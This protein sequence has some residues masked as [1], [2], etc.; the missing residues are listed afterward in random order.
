MPDEQTQGTHLDPRMTDAEALMWNLEKDPALRSSF[1]NVTFLDTTPDVAA[2]RRRIGRA[3]EEL[4]RLRQRVAPPPGRLAPPSWVDDPSFDLAFHVRHLGMP[5]PGTDRQL[6]DLAA[7]HF[8]DSFDRARPPWQFTIVEGLEGG[9]AA[10]L[11]KMHHTITDGVGGVRLSTSFLDLTRDAIDPEPPPTDADDRP[12]ADISDGVLEQAAGAVAH[13]LRRQLGITRRA[14][15]AA[16]DIALH[17]T[18]IPSR[19]SD[20]GAIA[21]S[22]L[23]QAIITDSAHSSLWAGRRSLRRHFEILTVE[24]SRLKKVSNDLGGSVNDGFVNCVAGGAAA[25]HRAKG[26]PVAELRM[27]MPVSTRT[28][29]SVGGNSFSPSRVLVPAGIEHPE[30]RFA[31]IHERVNATKSERALTF[32]NT[33]AGVL[34]L[35][36]T[37][38]VV[39]LARQQTETVDFATSNVRGAPFDLYV[40][41]AHILGNHPMG[42]TGGTAFNATVLSY[43]DQMDIGITIDTAAVDDPAL[44]R[45]CMTD[46]FDEFNALR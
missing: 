42:P 26:A 34:N 19:V 20:A 31:A 44:L 15:S 14:A 38:L 39:N 11:A 27:A 46:S 12:F 4:P 2:F 9:R 23:R 35:L 24:L 33:F 41:G 6:L 21:S 1:L 37:G 7:L 3:V 29:K 40:A 10:L 5:A 25:Y 16:V 8:E 30:E 17:P 43:N 28:D 45:Q 18:S 13:A 36:P 32:T 22:L